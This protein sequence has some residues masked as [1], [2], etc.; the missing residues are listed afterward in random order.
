[1]LMLERTSTCEAARP[2]QRVPN[3]YTRG[4]S[5]CAKKPIRSS[6]SYVQNQVVITRNYHAATIA[7]PPHAFILPWAGTKRCL[8]PT[9]LGPRVVSQRQVR[10]PTLLCG[11]Y[12]VVQNHTL[13]RSY[14]RYSADRF[15]QAGCDPADH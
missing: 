2:S 9:G 8:W 15:L 3:A 10:G 6:G 11:I 5:N 14:S 7:F 4:G 1:M 13:A 12:H